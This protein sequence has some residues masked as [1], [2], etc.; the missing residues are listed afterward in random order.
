MLCN[1]R[2]RHMIPTV[3]HKL[4]KEDNND[5]IDLA[6][7]KLDT[8]TNCKAMITFEID[9][10]GQWKDAHNLITTMGYSVI[11]KGDAQSL[12]NNF[13]SRVNIEGVNH[14]WQTIMLGCAFLS[15][16]N[17][18]SYEWAFRTFLESIGNN[19]PKTILTSQD[20]AMMKV[21]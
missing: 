17:A 6:Y 11:E 16:E 10:D 14:H 21:I 12:V 8:R 3:G 20:Q 1:Q 15:N 5:I 9:K 4:D 19:S 13:K 2:K 7:D 18:E